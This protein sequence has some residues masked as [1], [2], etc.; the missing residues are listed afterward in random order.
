MKKDSPLRLALIGCGHIAQKRH[1]PILRNM[2]GVQLVAVAD[3]DPRNLSLVAGQ[4]KVPNCYENHSALLE[5]PGID[6]VLV[7]TPPASHFAHTRDVLESGRHLYVDSPL[8]LSVEDCEELIELGNRTKSVATVGMNLRYHSLIQRATRCI[9]G[10]LIGPVHA[11]SAIFSTPSRGKR[12]DIFPA[13]RQPDTVDGNVFSESALQHFDTW[14]ALTGAEFTDVTVECAKIGGPVSLAAKMKGDT[15]GQCSPI[16]VA[17]VFSEYSGD[18]SEI[19]LI[20]RE[21]TIALSL[22]RFDGFSYCPALVAQGS[23]SQHLRGVS[24]G[25]RLIRQGARNLVQGGE[26]G[27]T[28]RLQLEAFVDACRGGKPPLVSLAD[29]KAAVAASLAAF[30]SLQT[31]QRV[32]L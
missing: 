13:W 22:Y 24:E 28:F 11:I 32:I 6:A 23:I 21:G 31:N 4:Y 15:A 9:K 2:R 17:A 1:L 20:G 7:S 3:T 14:R 5:N 8:A 19:R 18:N 27:T 29:G 26:Y 10:G 12:G 25:L 16:V 30:Q